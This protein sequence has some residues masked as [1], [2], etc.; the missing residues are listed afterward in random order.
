MRRLLSSLYAAFYAGVIY[1]KIMSQNLSA[2][3]KR[4][5]KNTLLLY[6]RQL[7]TMLVSLYT[8]RVILQTLGVTDFGIY[9][10]VGGVVGMFS[11][12][13][14]TLC[15]ATQRYLAYDLANGDAK[16]LRETFGLVLL[17]YIIMA[18]IT[19]ILSESFAVWFLNTKMT[20]PTDR[21]YA[22]NWVLQFAILTF[23][24]NIF[25][26]PYLSVVI[27]HEQMDVYAYVSIADVVLKLLIVFLLQ[28]FFFDKLILY[29]ILM[30]CSSMLITL[31]YAFYCHRNYKESHFQFFYDKARF[32]E[33]TAFAWWNMIGALAKVLRSQGINVLLNLFFNPA[34]NAA[35]GIA[36]QV[37]NA[38]ISFANNFYTAVKP[39]I[40][41]S[42][43]I[44]E[45][46]HM[47]QLI[48]SSSK[49]AFYLLLL[50]SLPIALNTNYILSLWLVSP[51]E[52][53]SL[54]VQL[55]LLNALAEVFSLPLVA[56]LQ[57]TGNIKYLQL[58]VSLLY[59]LNIPI[60]YVFLRLGYP[61]ETPMIVSLSLVVVCM[62][63]RLLL[64][65]HYYG[66]SIKQ[67]TLDVLVRG[68][69]IVILCYIIGT[70]LPWTGVDSIIALVISS[71]SLWIITL[72]LILILGLSSQERNMVM[73]IISRR[74]GRTNRAK[75]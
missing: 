44:G 74:F 60:S 34:I 4:I 26:T 3:N 2:D 56:G 36:Y 75:L 73:D 32:V 17:T 1:N 49:L 48:I 7:L 15:S 10:V 30:F 57:A 42:H 31:C 72:A 11:F 47:R 68:W 28:V 16:R 63:P 53:T 20:I 35:R 50:I 51:P 62:L 67:Y 38:I 33:M 69:T 9:N 59:L 54:F 24:V 58:S 12:L 40:I 27:A 61:P 14:G 64:C 29:S 8:S 41:K 21:I 23:V 18:I 19:V 39:Q 70:H 71:I 6:V 52:Y 22:A 66:L 13:T 5:A 55:V 46:S 37:N 25:S 65:K 43:A 45:D